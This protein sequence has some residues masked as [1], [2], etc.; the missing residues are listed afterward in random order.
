MGRLENQAQKNETKRGYEWRLWQGM[1]PSVECVAVVP[2]LS[3]WCS[4]YLQTHTADTPA[5]L[6]KMLT[7]PCAASQLSPNLCFSPSRSKDPGWSIWLPNL[8]HA[9]LPSWHNTKKGNACPQIHASQSIVCRLVPSY[10]LFLFCDETKDLCSN[11]NQFSAFSVEKNLSLEKGSAL[12]NRVLYT[13]QHFSRL[14]GRRICHQ[15]APPKVRVLG[16]CVVK[17]EQ[18]FT[19]CEIKLRKPAASYSTMEM[20]LPSGMCDSCGSGCTWLVLGWLWWYWFWCCFL[21]CRVGI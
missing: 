14:H 7:S 10:G 6:L 17:K 9:H 11:R 5:C 13:E 16:S 8:G 21:F 20:H 15:R 19:I 12:P 4:Q 2:T 3:S 1:L 18:M